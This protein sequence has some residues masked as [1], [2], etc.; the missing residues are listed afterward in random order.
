[1]VNSQLSHR[2]RQ[3]QATRRAVADAAR[4]LFARQGYVATTIDAIATAAAIPAPTIYSAFGGKSAILEEIRRAWV[5]E[6]DV[7]RLHAE[8]MATVDPRTRLRLAAHWTRRQFELGHDVI[9][10]YQEAGRVDAGAAE[11]W[12]GVMRFREGKI[13]ALVDSLGA[14][15]RPEL[16][17]ER[18]LDVFVTI[19]TPEMFGLFIRRGWSPDEYE[20]WLGELLIQQLLGS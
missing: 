7:E 6:S 4:A 12:A 8:A 10:I 3:A 11:I 9:A 16:L 5:A 17:P 13:A 20:A 15:L 1:M 19:T 14:E 18:A 2:Q